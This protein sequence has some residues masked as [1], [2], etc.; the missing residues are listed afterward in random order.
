MLSSA[1]CSQNITGTS[2][3]SAKLRA[4]PFVSHVTASQHPCHQINRRG[5]VVVRWRHPVRRSSPRTHKRPYSDSCNRRQTQQHK[6]RPRVRAQRSPSLLDVTCF[7]SHHMKAIRFHQLLK[8]CESYRS[9]LTHTHTPDFL[10][11]A[12]SFLALRH[13]K[14]KK[15]KE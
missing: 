10:K 9:A 12:S 8:S 4:D 6:T 7:Q 14:K 11:A 13:G 5:A 2:V 15:K 3:I 1:A